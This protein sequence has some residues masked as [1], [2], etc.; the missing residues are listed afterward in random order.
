[1]R[2]AREV[3]PL[4][5]VAFDRAFP[6]QRHA[7]GFVEDDPLFPAIRRRPARRPVWR[8]QH[9]V[10]LVHSQSRQ[11]EKLGLAWLNDFEEAEA[12]QTYLEG[13]SGLARPGEDGGADGEHAVRRHQQRRRGGVGRARRLPRRAERARVVA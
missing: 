7:V 4:L 3:P 13:Q 6:R 1:M 12:H 2:L 5:T 11:R 8:H 10:D 9:A